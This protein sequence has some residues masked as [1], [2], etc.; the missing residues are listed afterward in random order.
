MLPV[1][2]L[3]DFGQLHNSE[4]TLRASGIVCLKVMCFLVYLEG[5]IR[6]IWKTSTVSRKKCAHAQK[7]LVFKIAYN[8]EFLL[9]LSSFSLALPQKPRISNGSNVHCL[10]KWYFFS[11]QY[12]SVFGRDVEDILVFY[13]MALLVIC[14]CFPLR[15]CSRYNR[16]SVRVI[17]IF[18]D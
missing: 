8:L 11:S 10:K 3:V 1:F 7:Y 13:L 9:K 15:M 12:K 16:V 17:Y 6:L 14:C 5:S 4:G 18:V 2:G